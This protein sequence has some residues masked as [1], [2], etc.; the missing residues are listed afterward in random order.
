LRGVL[1]NPI[2]LNEEPL[3][4]PLVDNDDCHEG[5]LLG[6]VVGL[7]NGGLEL[8]HFLEKNLASHRITYPIPIYDEMLRVVLVLVSKAPE[9]PLDSILELR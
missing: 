7:I 8:S 6:L 1:E 2:L 9:C 3:S 4:D 5:L